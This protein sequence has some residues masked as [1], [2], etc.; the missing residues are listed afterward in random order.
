MKTT[1]LL[2]LAM[3]VMISGGL[4]AQDYKADVK[5]T[6]IKWEGKKVT[7]K[8]D[9]FIKLKSGMLQMKDGNITGGRFAIDMTTITNTDL[10]DPGTNKKLVDHLKSDDFFGVE[11]YPTAQFIITKAE[12]FEKYKAEIE[13]NITIKETTHP[14]TFNVMKAHNAYVA[15]IVIDRSK[16]NVRYGSGSFF[17]NLG[18]KMIYDDFTLNVKLYL[19]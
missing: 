1:K 15:T 6:E 16:F 17:D 10:E 11:K 9:G 8:H 13:G 18:D 12:P 2:L 5:K 3:I 19:E 4:Y 7:G 14:I